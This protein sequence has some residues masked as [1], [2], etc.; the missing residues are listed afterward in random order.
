LIGATAQE[1]GFD[2][3]PTPQARDQLWAA[4]SRVMPSLKDWTLADH[5]AGLRPKSPDGLPMLGRTAMEGCFPGG[6]AISQWHMFTPASP[7][8]ADMIWAKAKPVP[9]FRPSEIQMTE[10]Q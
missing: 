1:E 3:S 6:A 9:G 4:A 2:T 8:N 5:W 10:L 7:R